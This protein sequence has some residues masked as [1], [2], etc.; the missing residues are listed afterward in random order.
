MQTHEKIRVMRQC[1]DWT[2]EELAEKLGWSVNTYSKMERGN[3]D[4][5]LDK[6]KQLADVMG[7]SVQDLTSTDEKTVLNYAENCTYGNNENKNCTIV[8]SETQCVHELEK[9]QLVIADRD[10][11][12][13][14]LK[15]AILRLKEII[16]LLKQ[17]T[18][19][20]V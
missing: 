16:S 3:A 20:L 13:A 18:N 7:V 4:I 1:R 15:E 2:Q 10:K 6:L 14:Y 8:L 12:I 11:E 9:A 5:K 19:T 17:N